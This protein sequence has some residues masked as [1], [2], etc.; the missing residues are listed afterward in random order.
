[1]GAVQSMSEAELRWLIAGVGL[2][3]LI[4]IWLWGSRRRVREHE[5]EH[6]AAAPT[7][8]HSLPPVEQ[9]AP[10]PNAAE[11]RFGEYGAI[12]PDH[13]LADKALVD[14]EIIPLG[15]ADATRQE[16]AA[17]YDIP[18][19]ESA[20]TPEA[21]EE[22]QARRQ[23]AAATA[24]ST[25]LAASDDGKPP[26]TIVMT[27]TA[28]SA[29]PF[30]GPSILLAAQELKLKL[31][32]SGVFDFFHPRQPQGKP[33]FSIGQLR[34]PGTFDLDNIGRL[35]T[36]G[37]VLYMRLPGAAAPLEAVDLLIQTAR[38]LAQKL[39]GTVCDERR[40]RMTGQAYIK[41]RSDAAALEKQLEQ[42]EQPE[43][44]DSSS[45]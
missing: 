43:Q 10:P 23:A 38:E 19:T 3:I 7:L 31:H 33:V 26:L 35:T 8:E 1:M 15:R 9:T 24:E 32:R 42:A 41:L 25:P 2:I 14:V 5:R 12:T 36:P 29:R 11:Y 34:E 17:E 30:R 44:P 40:E 22:A 20:A 45:S 13:H 28:P 21:E 18:L 27:V 16:A 4:L 6:E 37:L 39:G